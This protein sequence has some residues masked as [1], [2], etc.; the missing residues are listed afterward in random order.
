MI[1]TSGFC[2]YFNTHSDLLK[3]H[4]V[5]SNAVRSFPFVLEKMKCPLIQVNTSCST[6]AI[7]VAGTFFFD[8]MS[9]GLF[10]GNIGC[11]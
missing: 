9:V 10:P 4:V 11:G 8:N 1:F 6:F 2:P 3:R 5:K 7:I